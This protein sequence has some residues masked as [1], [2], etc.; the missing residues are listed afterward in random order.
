MSRFI[1][2]K[3]RMNEDLS[4]DESW[5]TDIVKSLNDEYPYCH[6]NAKTVD[7]G[8]CWHITV[9]HKKQTPL[10]EATIAGIRGHIQGWMHA[11]TGTNGR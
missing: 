9:I 2:I 3:G 7:G 6:A 10:R 4:Q 11:A 8:E 5:I 1:E